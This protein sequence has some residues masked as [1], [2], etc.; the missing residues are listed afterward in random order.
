M[1]TQD[2]ELVAELI[3]RAERDGVYV[4]D[5]RTKLESDTKFVSVLSRWQNATDYEEFIVKE[6]ARRMS[7]MYGAGWAMKASTK[8]LAKKVLVDVQKEFG[9]LLEGES[10]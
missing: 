3:C 8:A 9:F 1:N 4:G 5:I 6:H 10:L 2:R 7:E